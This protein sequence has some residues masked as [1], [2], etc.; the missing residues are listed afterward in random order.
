[1]IFDGRSVVQMAGEM[2]GDRFKNKKKRDS[3]SV[4]KIGRAPLVII[5]RSCFE[6]NICLWPIHIPSVDPR[7]LSKKKNCQ[8]DP[9][10][11][12]YR[13][14]RKPINIDRITNFAKS[15]DQMFRGTEVN[16]LPTSYVCMYLSGHTRARVAWGQEIATSI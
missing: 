9:W 12:L 11:Y 5:P 4:A 1:M 8:Y 16:L 14:E 3:E 6:F 15:D 7:P 10:I 13:E 2:W